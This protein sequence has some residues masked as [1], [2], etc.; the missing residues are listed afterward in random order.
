MQ[1]FKSA[2][3]YRNEIKIQLDFDNQRSGE[4]AIGSFSIVEI[5]SEYKF[6][7]L[8]YST[9]PGRHDMSTLHNEKTTQ[10]VMQLISGIVHYYHRLDNAYQFKQFQPS[11]QLT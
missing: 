9:C 2:K 1:T 6:K 7:I 8:I 4:Y 5:K 11:A 10:R 3:L